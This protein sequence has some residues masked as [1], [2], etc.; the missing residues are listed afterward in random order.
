MKTTRV[1]FSFSPLFQGKNRG[2]KPSTCKWVW[3]EEEDVVETTWRDGSVLRLVRQSKGTSQ[4]DGTLFLSPTWAILQI[5]M[6]LPL[7]EH[8]LVLLHTQNHFVHTLL[9]FHGSS[10]KKMTCIYCIQLFWPV[11]PQTHAEKLGKVYQPLRSALSAKS[12]VSVAHLLAV[13][14]DFSKIL[15][16]SSGKIREKTAC[17]INKVGSVQLSDLMFS[18]R[19][20]S[21]T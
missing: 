8:L 1:F 6:K 14:Q 18:F 12:Q 16:T 9:T 5:L 19:F 20:L 11:L 13:R 10:I 15:R 3:G 17:A 4:P 7:G 2:Y 21:V